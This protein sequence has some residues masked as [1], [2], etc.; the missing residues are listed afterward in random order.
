MKLVIDDRIKHRL[1]GLVVIISIGVIF[2]P[3]MLK[4]S[5]HHLNESMK[6]SLKLPSKPVLP[7][8]AIPNQ[9]TMFQSVKV[10]HVEIPTVIQAQRVSKIAKAEPLRSK[11]VIT[12]TPVIAKTMPEPKPVQTAKI[13]PVNK[14]VQTA[15]V[16]VQPKPVAKAAI[17]IP[18]K[19][20]YAV[21]LAS[22]TQ[23]INAESLV[24]RLRKQGYA[25]SY[26]KF[27]NKQG[28]FYQVLV[29]QLNQKEQA[30][31]LQKKLASN[32]QLS[33]M[34]VKTGVS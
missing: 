6:V 29:G 12:P 34:I 25:A 23:K 16:I 22:F 11:P 4:K 15:K 8:V 32:M 5:T 30:L 10:A 21:Q 33:G 2:L 7:K 13:L 9:A 28:Q 24:S 14:P 20:Y 17:V 31:N 19:D 3:A 1:T 18:S 27:N 26:N